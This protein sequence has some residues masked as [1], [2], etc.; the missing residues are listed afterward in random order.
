MANR[1]KDFWPALVWNLFHP[2]HGSWHQEPQAQRE[3]AHTII[4][5]SATVTNT[6]EE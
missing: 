5:E 2:G 3:V 4:T 1:A 6:N